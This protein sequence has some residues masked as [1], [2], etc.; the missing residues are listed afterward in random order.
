MRAV[1]MLAGFVANDPEEAMY[2]NVSLDGEGKPLT[3]LN[4][5]VIHFPKGGQP[6]VNAFWSITIYNPE[7]NLVDN[8][9]KRY[10]LGDRSGMKENADG[11]LG[12]CLQKDSPG[13]DKQA[14]WLPAPAGNFFLIMRTYLPGSDLVNQ[15]WQPAAITV[16]N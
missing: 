2:I 15:T 10:S 12:I 13:P 8:P 6:K 7:Y 1:Q 11:S 9:I 4:R 14:N 5:Y 3:G 16:A